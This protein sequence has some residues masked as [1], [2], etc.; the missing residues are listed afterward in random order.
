MLKSGK[1]IAPEFIRLFLLEKVR[2]LSFGRDVV[3]ALLMFIFIGFLL[4]YLVGLAVFLG[5]ILKNLF[6]VQDVPSFL[7]EGA[8][9]YLLAEFLIRFTFQKKPLFDLNSFL[10]LPIK[11]SGIIHYL[12]ARSLF[13]PFSLLVI[14]LFV[15]VT[16]SDINPVYGPLYSSLWIATLFFL[17]IAMHNL[18]LWLKEVNDERFIGTVSVFTITVAPFLLLY[19]D[20]INLGEITAPFF[21]LSLLGPVPLIV[22]IVVC[23]SLL[24]VRLPAISR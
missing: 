7:N 9:F 18:V 14:I 8:V 10:H 17:S 1:Q 11:K 19:F 2:S 24:Y 5:L 15:P 22:S 16:I 3:S 6:E 4:F 13:S 21:N 12:L 23:I 20:V